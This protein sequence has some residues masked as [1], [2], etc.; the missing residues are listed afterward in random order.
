M[1]KSLLVSVA[2]AFSLSSLSAAPVDPASFTETTFLASGTLTNTTSTAW[3]PDGS[4]RLFLAQK[5]GACYIVQHNFQSGTPT[6]T[7]VGTPFITETPIY[8]NSE[9][10]LLGL[11]FDPDFVTNHYVYFFVTVSS[12]QQ[13]IVRYTASGNTGTARTVIVSGLP[14]LGQNHDGGGI[15]FGADGKLYWSIGDNGSKVGVDDNLTSM[16]AKV[17]RA[18]RDGTVPND[19]PFFDG[20]GPNN[21]YIWAR[22]F[23]NPFTLTFQP[24][25]GAL[26]LNVVGSTGGGQ[27]NPNSGPGYEQVFLVN[28]GDHGGYDNWENNQPAGYI[29]PKVAYGTAT[30]MTLNVS[31]ATTPGLSRSGGVVT[32]TTT[33]TNVNTHPFRRGGQVIIAGA[34]DASFNG[35]YFVSEDVSHQVFRYV[36][37]GP[38]ATSGSGTAKAPTFGTGSGGAALAGGTFYDSTAFPAPYRG[39]FFFGDYV[40]GLMART[41]LDAQNNV[42][43]TA[44]F[45]N[46]I[47]GLIDIT[48]GPDGALYYQGIGA[49]NIRRLAT[50]NTAQNVIVQ[51]T[52]FNVFEGGSAVATVRLASAP[53]SNVNV[54]VQR[55]SGDTS[56]A[57]S[58]GAMLTF[59]PANYFTPQLVTFTAAEDADQENNSAIFQVLAPGIASYNLIVH[60]IDN[61][62]P[63]IVVSAVN[64]TLDEGSS[65]TF[66]IRLASAP[67][68]DVTVNTARTSGD[69]DVTVS[70]GSALTFT[71]ANYATPQTVTVSAA[72]DADSAD[73]SAVLTVSA[74]GETPRTINVTVKDNDP[75]A[76]AFTSSPI[77]TAVAGAAYTYDADASG[78]PTPTFALLVSPTGMSIDA[79]TGIINWTPTNPGNYPVTIQASNN[80]STA[81]QS[82]TIA[83]SVD[84]PPTATITRPLP[85]E[86]VS[87]T[88]AEF[89][90]DGT[91]DVSTVKA[92]FFVDGILRYTDVNNENHF[93]FGGAHMMFDTTQFTNGSHL[94]A[95]RVT[96][97]AG[98]TGEQQV[99]VTFGSGGTNPPTPQSAVSRKTHGGVGSFDVNLPLSGP[100][101][102]ECRYGGGNGDHTV[103][104]T[105]AQ[106]VAVN[107]N[108]QA[109]V[110]AGTG[111]VGSGGV[112]NNGAVTVNG[113]VVTIPLT[114]VTNAQRLQVMLFN[115]NDGSGAGDVAIPMNVLLGDTNGSGDVNAID[116]SQTKS[117]S[118]QITSPA[119][120][121]TDTTVDGVTNNIDVSLVKSNSGMTLPPTG[122]KPGKQA[123]QPAR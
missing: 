67:A 105:F 48:T 104:V 16:A 120:F 80:V 98:Q 70:S 36:Q 101:G 6:G 33:N 107:G 51:P 71:P 102:V 3:A 91:D 47:P 54:T 63:Q 82:F 8:T 39:N 44:L 121:R 35:T 49:S 115:V 99:R 92:E 52:A 46:N 100:V 75:L 45:A 64:L 22:G 90:G 56:L 97:T 31:A 20:A 119:S 87:G 29:I 112:S 27:T 50:T 89:F 96:D 114:N 111:T 41:T 61:D 110:I 32:V 78:N 84:M 117:F 77:L 72:E 94:L 108:F 24:G 34:A 79:A 9:C 86:I 116:I 59:T 58:S 123:R 81:T 15:G 113:A 57:V 76:P 109:D 60:S 28:R 25:T 66:T 83:V 10:G 23:R 11:A 1:R 55:T 30:A 53:A 65:N 74:T 106:P 118:G 38:D 103:V 42:T 69:S 18:N 21:D 73:D 14:T 26:W 62:D 4:G 12:S 40:S 5:G 93:H 17:S 37:S 13:Q 88:H 85:G 7:L 95:M 122:A 68:S 43:S 19:N 2:L